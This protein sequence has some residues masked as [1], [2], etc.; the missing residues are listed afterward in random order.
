MSL[1]HRIVQGLEQRDYTF[2][3]PPD[4]LWDAWG[5]QPTFAGKQV[6]SQNSLG[7]T[8]VYSAVNLLATQ[9]GS[10]PMVV[11]KGETQDRE[12]ATDSWQ[13]DL[14]KRR[15]NPEMPA[16]LFYETLMG[17]LNL[18]GNFYLEK[19]FVQDPRVAGGRRVFALWPIRPDRVTVRRDLQSGAKFYEVADVNGRFDTATI[20][21]GQAFGYDG[22]KGL[23]PIGVHRQTLGGMLGRDEYMQRFYANQ[24]APGGYLT[25]DGTLSD[26]A[27]QRLKAGW[28]AAHR[29]GVNSGRVAVLE[30]G[31]SWQSVGMSLVDQQYIQQKVNDINECARI[32]QIPPEML[33]GERNKN[34][35]YANVESMS[36]H[37]K[38][39]SLNHWLVRIENTLRADED[40]FPAGSDLYPEFLSEGLLR[41]DSKSRVEYYQGMAA[42]KAITVNE[43]REKENMPA[44]EWGDEEPMPAGAP[45]PA[46][47]AAAP[48]PDDA[49]GDDP[50]ARAIADFGDEMR[51]YVERISRQQPPAVHF[52]ERAFVVEAGTTFEDGAIRSDVRLEE[53]AFRGGD[54]TLHPQQLELTI[55]GAA[56]RIVEFSDGRK[57]TI[58][59]EQ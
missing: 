54:V 10:L 4:W 58:E 1:V 52:H 6:N 47:P 23:S 36:I 19:Q 12:R 38:V 28:E 9:V 49:P 37:F 5:G 39:Y 7:L 22:L 8:G 32:F 50:S 59:E 56:K 42:V 27:A 48:A 20:I 24:A 57:V 25:V 30:S 45:A 29:G 15:P 34:I 41:G 13:W 53:G 16:D 40:L 44:V 11:Y 14:L 26:E 31:V 55:P 21:H 46:D 35:T 33:G 17:H 51:G 2:S 3:E 43:I 18:W